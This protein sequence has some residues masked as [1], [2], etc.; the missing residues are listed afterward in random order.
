LATDP[1]FAGPCSDVFPVGTLLTGPNNEYILTYVFG[2]ANTHLKFERILPSGTHQVQIDFS[3]LKNPAYQMPYFVLQFLREYDNG[4]EVVR[5]WISEIDETGA[6]DELKQIKAIRIGFVLLSDI[7]R[8]T[9]KG[10]GA[11]PTI[12][13]DYCPFDNMCYTLDDFN[14]S[15]YVFRKTIHIRNFDYLG[16]N[17]GISY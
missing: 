4:T 2:G 5:E 17:S 13:S 7:Q 1:V 10:S 16:I 15:A 9:K 11:D 3:S 6:P 8:V 14:K 12:S